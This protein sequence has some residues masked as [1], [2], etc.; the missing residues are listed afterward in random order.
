MAD[1]ERQPATAAGRMNPTF[2]SWN[3]DGR[4]GSELAPNLSAILDRRWMQDWQEL[5][6]IARQP[7]AP[8]EGI[9][10]LELRA[11]WEERRR[12]VRPVAPAWLTLGPWMPDTRYPGWFRAKVGRKTPEVLVRGY[13][14]RY[15]VIWWPRGCGDRPTVR[16][17]WEAVRAACDAGLRAAGVG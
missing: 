10:L 13:N 4:N 3:Y 17:T 15:E 9:I 2:A 14:G 1:V 8:Q 7:R 11:R 6:S 12:R 5:R 16:G